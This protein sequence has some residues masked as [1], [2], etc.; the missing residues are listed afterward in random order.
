MDCCV[1]NEAVHFFMK[2]FIHLNLRI[3]TFL[4]FSCVRNF[5]DVNIFFSFLIYHRQHQCGEGGYCSTALSGRGQPASHF[6]PPPCPCLDS[7]RSSCTK[8]SCCSSPPERSACIFTTLD[9]D[10]CLFS[11]LQ[12]NTTLDVCH[13]TFAK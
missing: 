11:K 7:L 5:K 10:A 13:K 6:C 9:L 8:T 3:I 2:L 12:V 4:F 1:C